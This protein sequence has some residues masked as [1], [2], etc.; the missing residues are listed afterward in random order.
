[1]DMEAQSVLKRLGEADSYFEAASCAFDGLDKKYTYESFELDTYP[2]EDTDHISAVLFRD[3]SVTTEE[4]IGIGDSQGDVFEVYGEDFLTENGMIV[5][6]KDDMKLCFIITDEVV[7]S[8]EYRTTV[9][10]E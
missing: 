1:M 4:G 5:Y 7:S 3:D 10:D 8:I 6:R 2:G 9:L